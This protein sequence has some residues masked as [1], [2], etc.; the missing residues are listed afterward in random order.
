MPVAV[1]TGLVAV[2]PI[3]LVWWLRASDT[4]TS[5]VLGMAVGM[6]LSLGASYLGRSYWEKRPGSEDRL[7]S[8]LMIWGF[9]HRW[10]T[11]RRLAS[12][13]ELLGSM[14]RAQRRLDDGLSAERQTKLLQ[15]LAVGMD[16]RDRNTHG[17]S[18]RVARHSWM[19]ARRI[20]L[21]R[22]EVSRIR[23]AAA[24]HDIGKIETPTEILR[25]N[26]PLNASEYAVI[27]R[28]PGAG[29]QMAEVLRDAELTSIVRHHHER[30]DGSGYPDAL[31]GESIPLG[32][33]IVAVADT[34]DAI[35][36]ARP[37]RPACPH[38]KA[39]DILRAE[40][41]TKLDPHVVRA[42]CGH[43]SGRRPLALW[44]SLASLPERVVSWLGGS[45]SGVAAAAKVMAV[46]A[47]VGSAAAGTV[48]LA[49]PVSTRAPRTTTLAARIQAQ[50]ADVKPS[51]GGPP[52]SAQTTS[53]RTP[54]GAY[55]IAGLTRPAG[56]RS[57]PAAGSAGSA[58]LTA[59]ASAGSQPSPSSVPGQSSVTAS[60][61]SSGKQPAE[62]Q[63]GKSKGSSTGEGSSKSKGPSQPEASGKSSGPEESAKAEK[64]GS[65]VKP[66][67][68]APAKPGKPEKAAKPEKP[69]APA[70]P[71]KADSPAKPEK[72][73]A[74]G[75]PEKAESPKPEKPEPAAK[76]EP[77]AGAEK[78][79][80]PGKP[81]KSGGSDN[82]EKSGGSEKSEGKNKG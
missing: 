1:A 71:E 31:A 55:R 5:S 19:I 42:F 58:A 52:A 73:D 36:S 24:I 45:L 3:S 46:A 40:A 32:A 11:E 67:K 68:P 29:A 79:E 7:F 66:E 82:A 22:E 12:A 13:R 47:V 15:Q 33:R 26:G 38:K 25:K 4:L 62:G 21:S 37:Y 78:P 6:G 72:A 23:T 20:G 39:L 76:P 57:V 48:T 35:T 27:K 80:P 77:P 34:F 14:N 63:T 59:S 9:L 44:A 18:R 28:H 61:S 17:H 2:L 50:G 16:A 41:G 53:A 43:Y 54:G 60:E 65:P 8:E 10:R 74:P 30:I 81:E 56:A 51:P 75:K 69:A 64:P 49:K 70:K